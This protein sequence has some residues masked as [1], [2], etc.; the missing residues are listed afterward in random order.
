MRRRAVHRWMSSGTGTGIG[1][2]AAETAGFLPAGR[3][4]GPDGGAVV[5]TR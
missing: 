4:A 3:A 2:S 1:D 5:S